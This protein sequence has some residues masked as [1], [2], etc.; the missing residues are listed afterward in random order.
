MTRAHPQ[1][2]PFGFCFTTLEPGSLS[3]HRT[4]YIDESALC[5]TECGRRL[6]RVNRNAAQNIN[7]D[8]VAREILR[9]IGATRPRPHYAASS[10]P[11]LAFT[12]AGEH[13]QSTPPMLA[14]CN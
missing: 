5:A 3:S 11:P 12:L 10:M 13:D 7:A 9:P 1:L 4:A 8:R 14:V 2:S 6:Q